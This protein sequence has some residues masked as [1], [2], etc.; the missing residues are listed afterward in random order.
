ML[1]IDAVFVNSGGGHVLLEEL[2]I[3]LRPYRLSVILLLDKRVKKSL[4]VSGFCVF[5]CP[6]SLLI[7]EF[8]IYQLRNKFL[9]RFCFGNIGPLV[10][11]KNRVYT[12]FHNVLYF[13]E[14]RTALFSLKKFVFKQCIKNTD[15]VIVQSKYVKELF[16]QCSPI[17]F[18]LNK[19]KV[20]PF[21]PEFK[22]DS[23]IIIRKDLIT[24]NRFIYV[25]NGEDYKNHRRLLAAFKL[26]S[27]DY[28]NIE[29]TLT[30]SDAY[31]ELLN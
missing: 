28:K 11:S 10:N 19:I 2:L 31:P 20:I 17:K 23:K 8:Y 30:I 15:F 4:D 6:S 5:Y 1:L 26:L 13:E 16:Y 18:E 27:K 22:R 14:S 3:I 24:V 12:F 21:F 29:L 25:S 7:R 9:I